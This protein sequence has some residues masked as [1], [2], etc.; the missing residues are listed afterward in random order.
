MDWRVWRAVRD[1]VRTEGASAETIDPEKAGISIPQQK[2]TLLCAGHTEE[3]GVALQTTSATGADLVKGRCVHRFWSIR[4]ALHTCMQVCY[5]I[6]TVCLAS[7]RSK[8]QLTM[9]CDSVM[10]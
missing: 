2:E 4:R 7:E 10:C 3:I 5:I 9:E 6:C 1:K 8:E